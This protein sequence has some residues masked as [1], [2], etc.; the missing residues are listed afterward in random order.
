MPDFDDYAY[1]L[2][3]RNLYMSRPDEDEIRTNVA[4]RRVTVFVGDADTGSEDLDQTCS[5]NL[6]G[7]NRYT[8]GVAYFGF[9]RQFY[10]GA[11]QELVV[12]PGV[13]HDH[14]LMYDSPLGRKVLFD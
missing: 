6:Q 3:K 8:R 7:P 4:R 11:G 13:A 12:I 1:G 14:R 10:P 9:L 2:K 5:A